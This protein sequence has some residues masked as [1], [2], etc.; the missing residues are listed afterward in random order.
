MM[1]RRALIV[2]NWKMN[3]D[4]PERAQELARTTEEA[5]LSFKRAE[6]VIAPPY[7]FIPAVKEVLSKVKLASQDAF[8]EERGPYTGQV[9]WRTLKSMGVSHVIVGHSERKK[10]AGETDDAINKKIQAFLKGGI[11]P[12]LCIGE[13]ERE[14]REIPRIV[15]DQLIRALSGVKKELIRHLVVAYEP[16]WAISTNLGSRPDTP[17]SAFRAGI[18]IRKILSGAYGR[19]QAD[20]VRIIY[21]GSVSSRT[22]PSFLREGGMQGALVGKASLDPQEFAQILRAASAIS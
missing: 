14:K 4:S 19:R 13:W 8:W 10:Y 22:I 5:N 1:K 20:A 9:S 15:E 21:G 17:D 16:V 12:I 11:T 7:P 18:Y 6:V 3:P 2:A